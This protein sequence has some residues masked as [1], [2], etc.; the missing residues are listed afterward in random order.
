MGLKVYSL[1]WSKE[2]SLFLL[3]ERPDIFSNDFDLL[4]D[5]FSCLDYSR[6]E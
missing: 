6:Q 5:I 1:P 4:K 3:L 2:R